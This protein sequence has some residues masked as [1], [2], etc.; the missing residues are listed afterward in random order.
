MKLLA[1]LAGSAIV[2]PSPGCA[3]LPTSLLDASNRDL[4]KKQ[5]ALVVE[6]ERLSTVSPASSARSYVRTY[7]QL[8]FCIKIVI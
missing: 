1:L 4:A 8:L 6:R 3:M 5:Q 7:V 2:V